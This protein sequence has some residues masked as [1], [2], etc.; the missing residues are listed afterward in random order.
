MP[1]D[2]IS[3]ARPL[4]LREFYAALKRKASENPRGGRDMANAWIWFNGY[5]NRTQYTKYGVSTLFH[6]SA[7]KVEQKWN[8]G[9]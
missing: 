1:F 9:M 7:G 2:G 6:F 8:G 3:H 5:D 4:G